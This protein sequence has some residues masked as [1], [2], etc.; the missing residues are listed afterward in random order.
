MMRSL[1]RL[2]MVDKLVFAS[3]TSPLD[4]ARTLVNVA[5]EAGWIMI[6]VDMPSQI[7]FMGIVLGVVAWV[8]EVAHEASLTTR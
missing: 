5:V 2:K 4:A 8:A 1:L 6:F 3:K 7:P